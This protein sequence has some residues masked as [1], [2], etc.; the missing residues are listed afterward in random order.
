[1]S[2]VGAIGW[3]LLDAVRDAGHKF[4]RVSTSYDIVD[5]SIH[6]ALTGERIVVFFEVPSMHYL[7]L[8]SAMHYLEKEYPEWL[9]KK[10]P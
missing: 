9:T 1:M 6:I 2:N 10:Q 7:E 3:R 4:D 8:D 5:D